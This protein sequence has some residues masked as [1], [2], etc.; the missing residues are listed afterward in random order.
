M[1][2]VDDLA[3]VNP[4]ELDAGDAEV[5]MPELT[6]DDDQRDALSGHL[7]R[8]R[9]A[10]LVLVPTSA[11]APICRPHRY[12]DETRGG[13]ARR[14]LSGPNYRH[15]PV[16]FSR[17]R[18]RPMPGNNDRQP[19]PPLRVAARPR[20]RKPHAW[21]QLRRLAVDRLTDAALVRIS[22]L[23]RTSRG[24][25]DRERRRVMPTPTRRSTQTAGTPS[26]ASA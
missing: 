14:Q 21:Q 1:D 5:C 11:Q 7:D 23:R 22:P 16:P 19:R 15:N 10:H 8:V 3:A 17:A 12:A 13:A 18:R 4:F 6:P 2:C 24:R 26:P 25:R 20:R 9:V